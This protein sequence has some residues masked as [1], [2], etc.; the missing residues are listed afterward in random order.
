VAFGIL[1]NNFTKLPINTTIKMGTISTE[2]LDASNNNQVYRV[3]IPW[4]WH[5]C[6]FLDEQNINWS[7]HTE[8][9]THVVEVFIEAKEPHKYWANLANQYAEYKQQM[10]CGEGEE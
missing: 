8:A 6:G 2:V 3:T 10:A 5:L 4:E 9:G 7:W 1:Q